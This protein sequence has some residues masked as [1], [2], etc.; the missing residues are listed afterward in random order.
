MPG[1]IDHAQIEPTTRC[2]YRCGFC[3]GRSMRQGD[4]AWEAFEAFLAAHPDL[5]H[6]ELQGEGEPLLHPR[7]FDMVAAC[8]ARGIAVGL[9]TNGSLLNAA[10][11]ERLLAADIASIHVSMETSDAARFQEIRGGKFAKVVEGLEALTR[12]R[13][14]LGF[15]RPSIGLTVTVLKDTIED[16]HGIYALYVRLGLDGGIAT[17]PLQKMAAYSAN[18]DPAMAEQALPRELIPRF[19]AIREALARQAPV[20]DF[21]YHS[22]FDG[23]D[24]ATR[25]CP[26][27]ERGA[28]LGNGGAITGCCFMKDEAAAFGDVLTGE[29]ERIAARRRGLIDALDSGEVPPPCRGCATAGSIVR[30]RTAAVPA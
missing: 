9:I 17:Q 4:L 12:R 29:A 14:E 5:R 25:S 26:W 19:A 21:F 23:F 24:P 20:R 16:I 10:M 3:V 13:R 28:F 8:R 11:V 7:F 2:N 22:L 1:R 18:Y 15:A 6:V 27:L 30:A